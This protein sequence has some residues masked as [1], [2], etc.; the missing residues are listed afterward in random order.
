MGKALEAAGAP[1]MCTNALPVTAQQLP[2]C[3][4]K[5]ADLQESEED[6]DGN[7]GLQDRLVHWRRRK[8]KRWLW[9]WFTVD[10]DDDQC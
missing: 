5:L 1:A 7:W 3:S 2:G 10:Y 4:F 9:N 8:V 6:D